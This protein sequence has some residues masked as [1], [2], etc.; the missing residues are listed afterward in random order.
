MNY[1]EFMLITEPNLDVFAKKMDTS[2]TQ[3]PKIFY[4]DMGALNVVEL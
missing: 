4:M 3:H 2:G 1:L